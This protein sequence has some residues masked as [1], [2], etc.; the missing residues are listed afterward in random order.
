MKYWCTTSLVAIDIW[1]I[2][3]TIWYISQHNWW[4]NTY[5]IGNGNKWAIPTY[6]YLENCRIYRF[7]EV[8]GIRAI[9][10]IIGIL[11][12][13]YLVWISCDDNDGICITTHL[14]GVNMQYKS[15]IASIFRLHTIHLISLCSALCI[16]LY[17]DIKN[18]IIYRNIVDFNGA[19]SRLYGL[20]RLITGLITYIRYRSEDKW[21]I[22]LPREFNGSFHW[23]SQGKAIYYW[24]HSIVF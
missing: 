22:W 12:R 11:R 9:D 19:G 14:L 8:L 15:L 18:I 13:K 1:S 17:L 24:N 10:P 2:L 6:L 16:L 4:A 3:T 7:Y 5:W 20:A 23:F 21:M